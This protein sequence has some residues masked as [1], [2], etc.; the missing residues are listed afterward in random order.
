M[1][2][3]ISVYAVNLPCRQDRRVSVC[4]QFINK[5]EFRFEIYNALE[6]KN[7]PWAL[8]QNFYNIV[9]RESLKGSDYFIFVEDDHVFTDVYEWSILQDCIKEAL[10]LKADLLSGGMSAVKNPI[11]VT[12]HLF[13]VST[14]NG[15]QFTIIFKRLYDRILSAKT[16]EGYVTDIHLSFLA[17]RKFVIYP[18]ISI[19]KDFGYSDAT[20]INNAEGRVMQFFEK[21]QML[22]SKLYKVNTYYQNIP[23]SL[24]ETINKTDVRNSFIP[25]FLINLK[26]RSDRRKHSIS[27]FSKYNEFQLK[28]VEACEHECGAVGL[29]QSICKIIRYAK[30]TNEDFILICEDDHFFTSNYKS[31]VFLRQIMLACAMGAQILNGGVG[32]FGNLV[33]LPENLYWVDWFWCTQFIVVYKSAYDIILNA[34]FTIRDVADV[35]LSKILTKK[36]MIAPFISEQ[37]DFGYSDVTSSNNKNAMVRQHFDKSRRQIMHYE[38]CNKIIENPSA[39]FNELGVSINEYLKKKCLHRL[40]LGCGFN[41]I[42]GW[43]NTDVEPTYGA[44]FLDVT[45]MAYIPS[46]SMD[47]IYAEHLFESFRFDILFNIFKDCARILKKTGTFR[48]VI[49]SNDKIVRDM[50]S[51]EKS[52]IYESYATWNL[53]NYDQGCDDSLLSDDNLKPG[54]VVL[55][56]FMKNF[57]SA[58]VYDFFIIKQLLT[59]AGFV[60]IQQCKLSKSEDKNLTNIEMHK[61]YKPNYIY[62][63]E[64]LVIEANKAVKLTAI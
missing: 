23:R 55:N 43:L 47:Y 63:Y 38:L 46:E 5:N 21:T 52:V 41:L 2:S 64:V 50:C 29:W 12:P 34:D 10:L 1:E 48:F 20:A 45:Q 31:E 13:W 57:S 17:K 15:M 18:Y 40:Q 3:P 6:S 14:F 33:K 36:M 25:T 26:N 58:Y 60:N 7:G 61:S 30:D 59:K 53:L 56:N 42:D 24:I 11:L 39:S 22:L 28:I 54:S 51:A 8:W 16:S 4:R 62:E 9:A 44:T 37:A 49:Y 35:K 19:Q 27:E 32:G